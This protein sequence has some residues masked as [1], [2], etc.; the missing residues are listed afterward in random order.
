MKDK[1]KVKAN[2]F[3]CNNKTGNWEE[4]TN[5]YHKWCTDAFNNNITGNYYSNDYWFVEVDLKQCE[6][7]TCANETEKWEF[8]KTNMIQIFYI[9]TYTDT[10]DSK[11]LIK[12]FVNNRYFYELKKDI[13]TSVDYFLQKSDVVSSS[14]LSFM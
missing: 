6:G 11:R 8:F 2:F 3:P 12:K 1:K 5:L 4:T 9:D 7:A 13:R 10:R 14:S